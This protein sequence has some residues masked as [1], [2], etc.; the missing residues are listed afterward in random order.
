MHAAA[1]V[2]PPWP[3][4]PLPPFPAM[5]PHPSHCAAVTLPLLLSTQ[6][7]K[8]PSGLYEKWSKKTRLRVAGG[9][10]SSREQEGA[11]L[12]AQMGD[13]CAGARPS[14]AVAVFPEF[15]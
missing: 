8:G 5:L 12:A 15:F 13:R 4:S 2:L 7:S 6:A 11:Q 10:G 9:G 1:S 14:L 3:L